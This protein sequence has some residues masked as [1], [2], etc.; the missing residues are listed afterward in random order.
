MWKDWPPAPFP[1]KFIAK[2]V[3]PRFY[4]DALKFC[5]CDRSGKLQ[6]LY[7]LREKNEA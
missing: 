7:A 6:P 3:M 1:V 4:G 2:T 5:S